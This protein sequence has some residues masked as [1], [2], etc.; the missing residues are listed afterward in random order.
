MDVKVELAP[1]VTTA[2]WKFWNETVCTNPPLILVFPPLLVVSELTDTW[3]L[4]FVSLCV[5]TT[6]LNGPVN[7]RLKEM[8]LP[9]A[10]VDWNVRSPVRL[11]SS[12][13]VCVP[14]VLVELPRL[15][16]V[17]PSPAI[18]AKSVVIELTSRLP[19][20]EVT[21]PVLMV[22]SNAP[23]RSFEKLMF[24]TACTFVEVKTLAAARVVVAAL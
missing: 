12:L 2:S 17:V 4:K 16:K 24:L 9:P 11:T 3:P 22:A 15:P 6:T 20:I 19:A 5:V 13:N 23:D 21:P 18:P 10:R 8:T 7:P 14:A 1:P